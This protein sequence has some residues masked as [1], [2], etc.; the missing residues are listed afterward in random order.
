MAGIASIML[1]TITAIIITRPS[2]SGLQEN[3][4]MAESRGLIC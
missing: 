4:A 2:N 1:T 3:E